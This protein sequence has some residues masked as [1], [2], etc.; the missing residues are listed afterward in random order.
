MTHKASVTP[1]LFES[2][3]KEILIRLENDR[4]VE[5]EDMRVEAREL[6]AIFR[7]WMVERP[8][9]PVRHDVVNRLFS[10]YRRT[11]NHLLKK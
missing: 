8:A 9:D 5:A 3:A 2:S 1:P 11:M 6:I 10:L 7:A 4:S